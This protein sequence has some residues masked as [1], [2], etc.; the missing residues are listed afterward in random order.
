M[1]L[2]TVRAKKNEG[3]M[4][5]G[6]KEEKWKRREKTRKS[7]RVRS[8]KILIATEDNAIHWSLVA[9]VYNIR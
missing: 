3:K 6:K 7:H 1:S 9:H 5:E 4:K 2:P 8:N